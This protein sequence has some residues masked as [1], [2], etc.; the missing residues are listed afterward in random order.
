MYLSEVLLNSELQGKEEE[1]VESA[2]LFI[3]SIFG[4]ERLV[5]IKE[6]PAVKVL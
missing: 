2:F 4:T 3:Y 1:K 6:Q 5:F